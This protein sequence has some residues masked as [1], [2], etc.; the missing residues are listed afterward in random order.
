MCDLKLKLNKLA[1]NQLSEKE[2]SQVSGGAGTW[3]CG[4]NGGD[5]GCACAYANS[6]GASTSAN[7]SA[8]QGR[9]LISPGLT[10][11]NGDAYQCGSEKGVVVKVNKQW[12][13]LWEN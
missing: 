11:T 8:N 5:C 6:G 2:M 12:V 4:A 9:S 10:P 1:N 13:I 3:Y 7:G